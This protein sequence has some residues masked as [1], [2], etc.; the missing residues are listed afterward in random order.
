VNVSWSEAKAECVKLGKRL[1][2]E[3]EWEK[4]CKGVGSA[5]F[6]Y[7]ALY[8][9]DKCNTEGARENARALAASGSFPG[10]QS[11]YRVFDMSGNAAE[12][13]DTRYGTNLERTQKGGSFDQPEGAAHCAA[14]KNGDPEVRSATV[15]FRCC[16]EMTR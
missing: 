9:P 14:R 16:S 11:N 6:P 13:T 7:G 10:C 5:R 4:A 1:C 8:D 12:W 15:G 2:T 3:Q